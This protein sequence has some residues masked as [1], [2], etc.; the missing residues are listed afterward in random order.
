MKG[1]IPFG[2]PF[3]D[4][5]LSGLADAGYARVCL[6][7]GPEHGAVREYYEG[8]GRPTRLELSFAIQLEPR[9][10]ADAVLAAETFAGEQPFAVINADNYYP[11]GALAALRHLPRAGLIG[12]RRDGLLAHGNIPSERIAAFALIEADELG[13]LKRIAEK[14]S[15]AEAATFGPD[16]LVSMNAWLLPPA[17]FAACRTVTPSPRGELELQ[18]AVRYAI[19]H[20]GE[21]FLVVESREGVLDLS[22]RDDIPAVG[23]RLRHFVVRP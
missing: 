9:G 18:D 15:P 19:L 7:I 8:A 21:L 13:G 17:I 1:M 12:F 5:V 6:V 22:N 14:P 4:Y 16:P 2:R 10:T 3:L 23:E 20:L 11:V